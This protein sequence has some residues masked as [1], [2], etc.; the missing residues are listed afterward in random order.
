MPPAVKPK[1]KASRRWPMFSGLA[2]CPCRPALAKIGEPNCAATFP[3]LTAC[4]SMAL[5][6]KPVV[7]KNGLWLMSNRKL[8][9]R[10]WSKPCGVKPGANS[11]DKCAMA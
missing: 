9:R 3:K 10:A 8:L 11:R 2:A 7:N 5:T 4:A 1:L 6:P